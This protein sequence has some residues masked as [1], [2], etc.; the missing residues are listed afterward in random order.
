MRYFRRGDVLRGLGLGLALS[1]T[2]CGSPTGV[3]PP[4][5]SP[6]LVADAGPS[7][8]GARPAKASRK[9]RGPRAQP[10]QFLDPRIG[11]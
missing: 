2:G 3:A 10:A 1:L 5:P 7:D 6:T 4:A 11:K 8:S 9:A